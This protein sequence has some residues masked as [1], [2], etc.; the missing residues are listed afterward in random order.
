LEVLPKNSEKNY[1]AYKSVIRNISKPACVIIVVPDHLH[2]SVAKEC[3]KAKL[4]ILIVKPLT[5]TIKEGRTL[6]DL[7]KKKNVYGAVEFH[8]R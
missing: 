5:P 7:A 3:I 1:D 2:Y 4:N 6:I 8:K